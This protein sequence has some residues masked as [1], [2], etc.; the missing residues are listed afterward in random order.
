MLSAT[1]VKPTFTAVTEVP[2]GD[3]TMRN[4][5]GGVVANGIKLL[6]GVIL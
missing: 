6:R 1:P 3:S 5:T 4:G 2:Q